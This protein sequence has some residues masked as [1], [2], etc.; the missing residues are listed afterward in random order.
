MKNFRKQIKIIS[1]FWFFSFTIPV[2]SQTVPYVILISF[3]GFRWDYPNKGITPNITF[4]KEHG[5]SAASF[6]PAFPSKTFPNHL[7]IITGM[8]PAH[9]GIIFNIIDDPYTHKKFTLRD[10]TQV[11]NSYWY[12]G[13]AF[14]ETAKRQG[15]K[16]ASYFWPGSSVDLQYR[17]PD[18]FKYYK[19][20]TP[21]ENRIQ[22][23][24]EWLQLPAEER[25]HFLTLYFS[26]ADD[27][28]HRYGPNSVQTD[29]AIIKLDNTLGL[30]FDQLKSINM[31]DSVNIILV[32]DHGMTPISK[33]RVINVDKLLSGYK[34]KHSNS[35]P[36]MMIQPE[37]NDIEKVY[38][39][40]KRNETHFTVY[41]R[42]E[43]PEYF[44]F[45]DNPFIYDLIVVADLGW[46]A[47][48]NKGIKWIERGAAKGNH[49]YDNH[50]M[51]MNGIFFA[52]GPSFKENYRTGTINCV[53]VYPLLCKIFNIFPNPNIDGKL[54]RIAFILK[55]R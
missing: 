12:K 21:Y 5:S 8:Y 26:A 22:K 28:G 41:K 27:A 3:D 37:K 1:F 47:L 6:Q 30:L 24:S 51:D 42:E 16:T 32:S 4:M 55:D 33:D 52:M 35:G 25:P 18:Y 11:N 13:E 7:S 14:W 38:E 17:R 45:S 48:T 40:L 44:H 15:I 31:M 50:T 29:S 53:D 49:G 46:S 2:F 10:S 19:K 54:N 23:I 39:I 43:M 9:H 20:S 36:V 34:F